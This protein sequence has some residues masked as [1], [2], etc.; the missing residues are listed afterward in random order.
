VTVAGEP[1][2][3]IRGPS[4]PADDPWPAEALELVLRCPLC[5]SGNREVLHESLKDTIC[6][7]ASGSWTLYRCVYCN[8]GYLDPRPTEETI[9][10]AYTHYHTHRVDNEPPPPNSLTGRFR[11]ALRNGYLNARYNFDLRPALALGRWVF[12]FLPSIRLR[13]DRAVRHLRL[14]QYR[15]RILDL[16]CGNGAFVRTAIGWG[17]DAEGLDPDPKAAA[18]SLGLDARITTGSLSRAMYPDACF[19]A[20]TMDHTIEHLH[21]PIATLRE[22]YRILQPG[23]SLWVATPNLNAIGYRLFGKDWRGLEPPRHLVLFTAAT[24]RS[25]L[26]A[27]GFEKIE[28]LRAPFVSRRFFTPSYRIA[29]GEDPSAVTGSPLPLRLR[30]LAM[31]LDWYA[32]V[33]PSRG[34]EII[35]TAQRPLARSMQRNSRLPSPPFEKAAVQTTEQAEG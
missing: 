10:D 21:T 12:P 34:E 17:W 32:Y 7:S 2:N 28:P 3:P 16:G 19:A 8:S 22:V 18:A 27:A 5:G 25:A 15:A 30:L 26:A 11:R 20:V 29:R 33:Q 13:H 24:L 23:G 4:V 9:G 6:F 35:F 1:N 14:P 31:C